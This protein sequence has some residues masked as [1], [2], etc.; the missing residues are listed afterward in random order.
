MY[1]TEQFPPAKSNIVDNNIPK[2]LKNQSECDFSLKFV[3][4]WNM[5]NDYL[6]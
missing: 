3:F 5:A 4:K 6:N 1:I 2:C